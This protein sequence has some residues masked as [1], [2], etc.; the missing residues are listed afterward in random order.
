M[1]AAFSAARKNRLDLSV[2]IALGSA[3]QIALFVTPV[4]VLVSYFVGPTPMDL[5]FWP[6]A[7]I[8]IL[9][10][11]VV[12]SFVTNSGRSAWFVGVLLL[13][14][15]LIFAMTLYMLPPQSGEA[16]VTT[17]RDAFSSS[18]GLTSRTS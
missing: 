6:G 17:G 2:G 10:A 4:L 18:R 15:Y 12:A 3:A 11:T 1:A 8:M 14:V 7:V 16:A 5:H 9:I 13:M